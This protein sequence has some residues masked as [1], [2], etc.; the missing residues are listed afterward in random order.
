M[1]EFLPSMIRTNRGHMVTI[2]SV[3][4]FVAVG[5]M[6]DDCCSKASALAFHDGLRQELKYWYEAPNVLISIVHPLWVRAPMIKGF[7]SYQ[8][9]F[10]QLFSPKVVYEAVIERL[11]SR[12]RGQIVLPRRIRVAGSFRWFLLWMQEPVRSH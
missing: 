11:V 10:R 7:T 5:E 4:S 1:K 3:A 12:K 9:E 2:A 8:D 6:V